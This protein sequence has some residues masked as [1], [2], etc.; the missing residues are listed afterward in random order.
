MREDETLLP[1]LAQQLWV[2]HA[3]QPNQ[4]LVCI[5]SSSKMARKLC[6]DLNFLQKVFPKYENTPVSNYPNYT[7]RPGVVSEF[8]SQA[9]YQRNTCIYYHLFTKPAPIIITTLGAL[10]TPVPDPT[11]FT[12]YFQD[13]QIESD[14]SLSK[15]KSICQHLG[16]EQVDLVDE[17]GTFAPRGFVIDIYCPLYTDP[18]R[19]EFADDQIESISMFNLNTQQTQKNLTTATILSPKFF[20]GFEHPYLKELE[21]NLKT[22][23]I[24]VNQ[25]YEMIDALREGQSWETADIVELTCSPG[26]GPPE[27]LFQDAKFLIKNVEA[28]IENFNAPHKLDQE[29][30]RFPFS[31]SPRASVLKTTGQDALT[32]L[33]PIDI[34]HD[35]T[36][37][38]VALTD[39]P[40]DPDSRHAFFQE[41]LPLWLK[42][43]G[44][45]FFSYQ[46]HLH[47]QQ[48]LKHLEKNEIDPRAVSLEARPISKSFIDEKNKLAIVRAQDLFSGSSSLD[49][50][51]K[52]K[53]SRFFST[54]SSLEEGDFVIHSQHGISKYLGLQRIDI[55]ETSGEYIAME[56]LH[57]DK[58]YLPIYRLHLIQKYKSKGMEPIVP[59]SLRDQ[60]FSKRKIKIQE[61]ITRYAHELIELQARRE[62]TRTQAY[63]PS[64]EEDKFADSFPF[65]ETKDQIRSISEVLN[66]LKKTMPMDRLLCGD[67]GFG[68]TEVAFRALLRVISHG[69]QAAILTPT[70][71]LAHQHYHTAKLRFKDHPYNFEVISRFKTPKEQKVILER[72][73][74]GKIDCII[75]THRLLQKDVSLKKLGLIIVDEE[76]KFGVKQ[77]EKLKKVR[78]QTHTFSLSATPIPRTLNQAFLGLRSLSIITTPPTNRLPIHTYLTKPEKSI[79][80]PAIDRELSRE[81]QIFCVVPRVADIPQIESWFQTNFPTIPYGIAHGQMPEDQL[82]NIMIDFY[83]KKFPVLISTSIIESGLDVPNAN[84]MLVFRANLFGLSQLYQLRGRIGRAGRQSYCYLMLPPN[85]DINKKAKKRLEILLRYHDLGSGFQIAQHDL[86]VRGAGNVLGE[87]QTGFISQIGPELYFDML[88]TTI[89]KL[90][91]KEEESVDPEIMWGWESLL[92]DTYLPSIPLRLEVYQGLSQAQSVKEINSQLHE[93]ENR[94][95]PLPLEGHHLILLHHTRLICKQLGIKHLQVRG[96]RLELTFM[97]NPKLDMQVFLDF[98]EKHKLKYQF[99]SSQQLSI[100]AAFKSPDNLVTY[101]QTFADKVLSSS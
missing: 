85:T 61:K 31:R 57:Q 84:T 95:G 30:E 26:F 70:T 63:S 60:K 21:D 46:S 44:Q 87:E 94:F 33:H 27:A 41:W 20:L 49:I 25:K 65:D 24:P 39:L 23:P 34:D 5:V 78:V 6:D 40:Y 18:L 69:E 29:V 101:L 92:S 8:S 10:S 58:L 13:I 82:E 67:V 50:P 74:E 79:L 73:K 93:I 47:L 88:K 77:K 16:Y 37:A 90:Q 64:E 12:R 4:T 52:S 22:I 14:L 91:G 83:E 97:E 98:F 76:Q 3:G 56:F 28:C 2:Q 72:L 99:R 75:G 100:E 81:G 19:L 43:E 11:Y 38:S 96:N 17:V 32:P 86:E 54:L 62:L 1:G 68:K 48:I 89:H 59:D 15:I 36:Q 66:D 55:N 45:V 80:K 53:I 35:P 9:I 51:D 71:L 7:I 42:N